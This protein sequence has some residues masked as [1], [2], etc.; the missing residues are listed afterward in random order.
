MA[1]IGLAGIL[2]V[3]VI[4]AGALLFAAFAAIVTGTVLANHTEL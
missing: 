4:A 1:F 3:L 2:L